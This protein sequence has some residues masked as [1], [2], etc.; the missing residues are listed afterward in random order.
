MRA[1]LSRQVLI[2]NQTYEPMCL[3]SARKAVLLIY[4]GKAELIEVRPDVRIHSVSATFPFP[5]IIRLLR[6]VKVHHRRVVLSRKNII[7]R[8]G[9]KCQYC[10]TARRPLTVDHVIPR[11][12]GGG[13]TWE[14]LVCACVFCNNKK[15]DRTPDEANMPLL[16]RPKKPSSLLFIHQSIVKMDEKWK[17]YLFLS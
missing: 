16:N 15:G 13:D 2:L 17:P 10:G 11:K 3:V 5:S 8:D 12:R 7:M 4:L 9:G 14:N 6:F 1:T